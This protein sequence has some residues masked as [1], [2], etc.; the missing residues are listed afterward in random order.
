MEREV[1]PNWHP[2]VPWWLGLEVKRVSPQEGELVAEDHRVDIVELG[3][4]LR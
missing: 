1:E 3:E 4:L 2:P